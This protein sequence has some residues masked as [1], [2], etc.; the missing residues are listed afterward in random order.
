MYSF[1]INPLFDPTDGSV[2]VRVFAA[3]PCTPSIFD[4]TTPIPFTIPVGNR[5]GV[6][7]TLMIEIFGATSCVAVQLNEPA[8]PP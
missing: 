3:P 7:V 4:N 1:Y 2:C 6:P 8:C 5:N